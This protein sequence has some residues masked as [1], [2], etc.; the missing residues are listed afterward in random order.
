MNLNNKFDYSVLMSV[1][2]NDKTEYIKSAIESMINQ[3]IMP[4]QYVVV[5]DGPV[6]V[7][8]EDTITKYEQEHP[9]L[10]TII[11]LKENRGLGNALNIGMKECR[12]ELIARMDADDIS[13]PQR[14][15]RQL[16]KFESNPQLSILGTQIKEFVG[17]PSNIVSQ[18]KVP[19]TFKE[20]KKFAKRRSPFNHPTVMYKKSVI[21]RLGGYPSISRKE[22]LALF[23]LAV[24]NGVYSENL[25][26]PL[27]LYRT[28]NSNQKRRRTWINC[29]EYIQVMF[30]CYKKRYIGLSDLLYVILGQ[31]SLFILPASLTNK[32]SKR[33]LRSD[34]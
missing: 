32:L 23:V 8:I 27:L 16:E 4:K 19:I 14:C 34:V 33:Y 3:T 18:R 20:I 13:L 17:E 9:D 26:E 15:E 11:C 7:E 24:S 6:G 1:Y 12:Y 22:D 29:K 2:K 25:N 30:K 28:S 5:V 10:F 21:T 31:I